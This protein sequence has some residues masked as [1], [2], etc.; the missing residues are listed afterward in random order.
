MAEKDTS[1]ESGPIPLHASRHHRRAEDPS[2][3]TI[4]R[5]I[6]LPWVLGVIFAIAAQAA[7]VYFTQQRQGELIVTLTTEVK[8]LTAS[9][10]TNNVTDVKH[11]FKIADIERRLESLERRKP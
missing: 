10:N 1:E 6:P 8:T 5:A 2:S 7:V 9:V 3:F 11:D 4:T